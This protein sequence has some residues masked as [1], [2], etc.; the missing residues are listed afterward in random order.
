MDY[1]VSD[2]QPLSF[3]SGDSC[4]RVVVVTYLA[5]PS[6][7]LHD[8]NW[9]HVWE[10]CL[11]KPYMLSTGTPFMIADSTGRRRYWEADSNEIIV[12]V[13]SRGKL[14]LLCLSFNMR[15]HFLNAS[16]FVGFS[17]EC[18]LLGKNV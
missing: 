11:G 7:D 10:S 12:S 6:P 9:P 1:I 16:I 15:R 13:N 2:V 17:M 14:L 8:W 18:A 3:F 4:V 5:P